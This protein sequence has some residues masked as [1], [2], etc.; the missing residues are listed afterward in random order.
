MNTH[1]E[2]QEIGVQI[3]D[4][5]QADLVTADITDLLS[6]RH[7]ITDEGEEDFLI[8][9]QEQ[10]VGMIQQVTGLMTAREAQR[11]GVGGEVVCFVW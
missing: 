6:R 10:M 3:S 8:M 2:N 5:E 9:T 7:R 11:Q 1:S 4:L